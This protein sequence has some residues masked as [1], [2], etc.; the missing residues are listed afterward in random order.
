MLAIVLLEKIHQYVLILK[1]STGLLKNPL[2]RG[3][4]TGSAFPQGGAN[5]NS[6]FPAGK[7]RR[8]LQY[9]QMLGAQKP[10]RES[11]IDIR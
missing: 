7:I 5:I 11:Y 9:A 8:I 3:L 4:F 1:I 10:Y 2:F 6:T